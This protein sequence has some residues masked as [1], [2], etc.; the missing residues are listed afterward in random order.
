MWVLEH[1]LVGRPVII[2]IVDERPS[3]QQQQKSE[4]QLQLTK[5]QPLLL[6]SSMPT[7]L[8]YCG[9]QQRLSHLLRS[10]HNTRVLLRQG[11]VHEHVYILT[12][13]FRRAKIVPNF[14][15]PPSTLLHARDPILTPQIFVSFKSTRRESF[16]TKMLAWEVWEISCGSWNRYYRQ[17]SRDH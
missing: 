15:E 12:G 4:K 11:T 17:L 1:A 6:I 7:K 2:T 5:I 10:Y 13:Q 9:S 14:M 8:S 3:Q 16:D